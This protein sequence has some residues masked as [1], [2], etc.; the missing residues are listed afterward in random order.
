VESFA[1]ALGLDQS[2]NEGS[3]LAT[4]AALVVGCFVG[5]IVCRK[6]LR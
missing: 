4:I 6:V 1:N 3:V 2:M 5:Y